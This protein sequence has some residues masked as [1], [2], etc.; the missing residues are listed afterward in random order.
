MVDGVTPRKSPLVVLLHRLGRSRS[1]MWL[2]AACLEEAGF[3]VERIGYSSLR[4][5]PEEIIGDI[6][7]QIDA[8][9]TDGS[10]EVRFVGHSLGGLLIRAY[11]Q[12]NRVERLGSVVLVGTPN[13]GTGVVDKFRDNCLFSLLGP[14]TAALGTDADGLPNRLSRPYYPVGIVAGINQ[15][16]WNDD[17][18][19]GPDDGLVPVESTKLPGM[20][21]FIE[22][23]SSHLM[24][25]Y[26]KEVARQVIAF[27]RI[28]RFA[29]DP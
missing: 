11:L 1:A 19:P 2:L 6:T 10:H 27:L 29:R 17:W 13:H 4:R 7:R 8:C 21:D 28:G 23:E 14:T 5:S 24:M 18:L 25:R 12:E 20:A 26:N 15:S 3:R 16:E 22:V 9:C